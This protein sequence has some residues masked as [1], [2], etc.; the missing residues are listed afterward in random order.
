[1]KTITVYHKVLSEPTDQQ[2]IEPGYDITFITVAEVQVADD[3][4]DADALEFAFRWTNNTNGSWSG[5]ER[6]YSNPDYNADVEVLEPLPVA[7]GREYGHRSSMVGDVF[8]LGP[9]AYKV[10]S[11]GF[12][13]TS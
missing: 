6:D 8:G 12:E 4:S 13:L 1:M 5:G 7:N 2:V 3:I 10:M 11:C 9:R